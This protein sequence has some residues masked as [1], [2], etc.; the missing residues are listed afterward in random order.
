MKKIVLIRHGQS[1]GQTARENGISRRDERLKDCFLTPKGIQQASALRFD[2]RLS[3]YKFD[4]VCTSPLTRAV[5]TCV[6]ALGHLT[7]MQEPPPPPP[8]PPAGGSTS[9]PPPPTFI[10]HSSISETGTGIPE[11]KGRNISVLKKDLKE[12]LSMVASP[13]ALACL[14]H[15]DFSRIP[16][17]WAEIGDQTWRYDKS[18][19]KHKLQ[20]FL[21]WLLERKE[22]EIAV[23]CHHNII[24]WL[25]GNAI[26]HVPNCVPIECV[27]LAGDGAV[28]RLVPK[29]AYESSDYRTETFK[30]GTTKKQQE[31][32]KKIR[33]RKA[34][35]N[36]RF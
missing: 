8:P 23:V 17:S 7:E 27:L 14:D 35:A 29:S 31:R 36:K 5:A 10:A 6:L 30:H 22:T 26:G 25:V 12:K 20:V 13:S 33:N 15:I 24:R 34:P 2:A 21:Q 3:Q 9:T 4:L 19:T 28:P 1:L 16:N 32:R 18:E 11:N